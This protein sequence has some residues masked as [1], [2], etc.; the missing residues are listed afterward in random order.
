M[1]GRE[2]L[3]IN[4]TEERLIEVMIEVGAEDS[5]IHLICSALTEEQQTEATDFLEKRYQERGE[6][7]EQEMLRMLLIMTETNSSPA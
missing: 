6:V 3:M 2:L 7:T 5:L 4:A 1:K